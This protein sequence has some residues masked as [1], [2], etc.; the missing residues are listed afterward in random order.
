MDVNSPP[1]ENLTPA[2]NENP[3]EIVDEETSDDESW[4]YPSGSIK[5]L[6]EKEDKP[7]LLD[8]DNLERAT[9]KIYTSREDELD[10]GFKDAGYW[11]GIWMTLEEIRKHVWSYK[12]VISESSLLNA[13]MFDNDRRRAIK[14]KVERFLRINGE[15]LIINDYYF[16]SK[17]G[18]IAWV[19][20]DPRLVAEMHRR[21]AKS[22]IKDFRTMT[23]IPKLACDRKSTL[24]K[25]LMG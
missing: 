2:A 4:T 7:P 9:G 13:D 5:G 24:N 11:I 18:Y 14:D 1:N 21:A 22:A 6:K 16:T 15:Q 3:A 17:G 8:L 25:L 20:T 10:D 23:F 12:G 19:K